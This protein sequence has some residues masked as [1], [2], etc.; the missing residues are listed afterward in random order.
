MDYY[1]KLNIFYE[2]L[3]DAIFITSGIIYDEYV[4]NRILS[5]HNKILFHN[6]NLPIDD[7][8]DIDYDIETS[9]RVIKS[10]KIKIAY[11]N[12]NDYIKFLK[13]L[14]KNLHLIEELNISIEIT[15]SKD[16][17]PY[18]SNNYTCYGLLLDSKNNYYYSKNTGTPYDNIDNVEKKIIK[19][20]INKETQYLRGFYSNYEIL[21]D[22]TRMID[23]AWKITNL[24]YNYSKNNKYNENC[25]ICL[26]NLNNNKEVI[27]IFNYNIHFKCLNNYLLTQK[28]AL[29]FK[30]PYRNSIDLNNCKYF[31][32]F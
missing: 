13:F 25:P 21:L 22:I 4:C 2:L 30:C 11:K 6:K 28:N 14:N 10:T 12:N 26:N 24:P 8:Y 9:D 27:N 1:K 29:Y 15:I 20:I 31:T 18:K 23:D 16:E 7:F 19:E 3:E 32:T 5:N 17:P